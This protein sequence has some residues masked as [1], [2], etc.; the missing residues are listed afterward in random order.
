[1]TE[2]PTTPML[3]RIGSPADLRALDDADLRRVADELRA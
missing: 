1:M 2:R 3:D